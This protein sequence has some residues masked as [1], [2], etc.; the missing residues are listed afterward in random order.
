MLYKRVK[1][2]SNL[3]EK[4][5]S[6]CEICFQVNIIKKYN[7]FTRNCKN[8]YYNWRNIYGYLVFKILNYSY[9][10]KLNYLKMFDQFNLKLCL[11]KNYNL[12]CIYHYVKF[13]YTRL[14]SRISY[15]IYL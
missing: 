3:D 13:K 6:Q 14:L 9:Y 7:H 12:L 15:L 8:G 2:L 1:L 10:S 5:S 4:I 11:Q